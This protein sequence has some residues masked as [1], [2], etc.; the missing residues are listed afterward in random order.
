MPVKTVTNSESNF[1][2]TYQSSCMIPVFQVELNPEES[3]SLNC[4]YSI[5]NL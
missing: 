4:N 2:L 1:E 3:I 5:I